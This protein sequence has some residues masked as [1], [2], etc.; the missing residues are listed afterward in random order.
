MLFPRYVW[1]TYS[2]ETGT[3]VRNQSDCGERV[4]A[5]ALTGLFTLRGVAEVDLRQPQDVSAEGIF[6]P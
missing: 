6:T 4:L 1:L 3:L 2:D 5:G